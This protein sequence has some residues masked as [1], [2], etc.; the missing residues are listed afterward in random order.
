MFLIFD[1]S[2]L[3]EL[4]IGGIKWIIYIIAGLYIFLGDKQPIVG[5]IFGLIL[6]GIILFL[7]VLVKFIKCLTLK[8]DNKDLNIKIK[9]NAIV[10]LAITII[11]MIIGYAFPLY[12]S[13]FNFQL[14]R[15]AS[16]FYI[17]VYMSPIIVLLNFITG[18]EESNFFD[19]VWTT[20]RNIIFYASLG[21]GI[22]FFIFI[23]SM[24]KSDGKIDL[25]KLSSNFLTYYD[26]A[27]EDE[28]NKFENNTLKIINNSFEYIKNDMFLDND[29]KVNT[30]NALS[31]AITSNILDGNENILEDYKKDDNNQ[32]AFIHVVLR[33][34]INNNNSYY[35]EYIKKYGLVLEDMVYVDS[36]LRYLKFFDMTIYENIHYE[37]DIANGNVLKEISKDEF[38]KVYNENVS[39]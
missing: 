18:S 4:A 6:L 1:I 37:V 10:L 31:S 21:I 3:D 7:S 13:Y 34:S 36:N 15:I 26:N 5:L 35:N 30:K 39:K 16:M 20:I 23:V 11:G 12:L 8:N 9:R 29:V 2:D 38:E 33:N 32:L 25:V 27:Y 19:V 28:R 22:S 17:L 14:S 24:G